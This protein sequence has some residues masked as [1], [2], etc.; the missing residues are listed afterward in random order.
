MTE[1]RKIRLQALQQY[2]GIFLRDEILKNPGRG[3]A[4]SNN[5]N[6]NDNDKKKI[7]Y[8]ILLKLYRSLIHP[9]RIMVLLIFMLKP[10]VNNLNVAF[11]EFLVGNK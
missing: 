4:C 8:F 1:Q 9:M 2:G 7:K 11:W 10:L 3:L 5:N 6:N